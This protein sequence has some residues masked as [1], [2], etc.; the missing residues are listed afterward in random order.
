MDFYMFNV[1][2]LYFFYVQ[3]APSL[4][5]GIPFKLV[6]MSFWHAPLVF[7]NFLF[8]GMTRCHMF[9]EYFGPRPECYRDFKTLKILTSSSSTVEIFTSFFFLLKLISTP[10]LFFFFYWSIGDLQ[11]C[12]NF[13]CTAK[14]FGYTYICIC[15]YSF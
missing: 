11:F 9:M 10:F 5:T 6:P 8:S 15:L 12:V 3:S 4:A 2:I 13:R 7:D 14:W 1:S